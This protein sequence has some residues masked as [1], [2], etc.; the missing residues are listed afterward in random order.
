M[1]FIERLKIAFSIDLRSIALFRICLGLIVLA[2]LALRSFDMRVFYTDAGV[3]TRRDWLGATHFMQWSLHNASGQLWFQ[4]V[5]FTIAGVAALCLA[6][7]YRTRISSI[8]VWVLTASL[9]N[10]NGYV[11]QGGDELLAVL[12]FWAL[13]LIHI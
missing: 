11:L 3:L 5:L 2:D 13:S 1:R 12:T 9:I 8:V 7:G 10:R 6:A 4:I